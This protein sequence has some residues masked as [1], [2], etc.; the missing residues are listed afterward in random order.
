MIDCLDPFS[1][2]NKFVMK[3]TQTSLRSHYTFELEGVTFMS[4]KLK[5]KEIIK[6]KFLLFL[7]YM[8]EYSHKM[9]SMSRDVI[10]KI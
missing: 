3:K 2:Y 9:F 1:C 6:W 10:F 5:C 8:L 4:K 7:A